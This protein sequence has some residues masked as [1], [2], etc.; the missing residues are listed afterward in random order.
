MNNGSGVKS[1]GIELLKN[2]QILHQNK[3]ISTEEKNN[4]ASYIKEGMKSG[5]FDKLSKELLEI[6]DRTSQPYV[7]E[8]MLALIC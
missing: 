8:D 5:N 6:L 4:M 3:A 2:V 7:I 1:V